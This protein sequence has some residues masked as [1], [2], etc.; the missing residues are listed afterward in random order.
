M[1]ITKKAIVGGISAFFVFN[2]VADE[3]ADNAA[4]CIQLEVAANV[5]NAITQSRSWH[6]SKLIS[7]AYDYYGCEIE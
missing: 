6:D 7:D 3:L 5:H 2:Y 4:S 1:M